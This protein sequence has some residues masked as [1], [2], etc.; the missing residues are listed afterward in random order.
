MLGD[1]R[2]PQERHVLVEQARTA[3]TMGMLLCLDR[4][5][6][7][8]LVLGEILELGDDAAAQVLGISRENFRQRLARARKDL[9][10][11]LAGRCGLVDPANACRCAKKTRGFIRDGIVDPGSLQ[12]APRHLSEVREKSEEHGRQ[13]A[14]LEV[15]V[16]SDLRDLFPPFR[17]PDVAARVRAIVQASRVSR[18]V[19]YLPARIQQGDGRHGRKACLIPKHLTPC[20]VSSR[21]PSSDGSTV[22]PLGFSRFPTTMSFTSTHS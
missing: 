10:T 7:L 11:F 4:G 14:L 6:R 20:S 17:A 21:R 5:Q 13:L 15:Q 3:C 2:T 9:S 12:F 1:G 8:A 19:R 22:T 16:A 18:M